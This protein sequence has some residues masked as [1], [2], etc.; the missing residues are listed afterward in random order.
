MDLFPLTVQQLHWLYYYFLLFHF[1]PYF[2]LLSLLFFISHFS[3]ILSPLFSLPVSL[4]QLT[5]MLVNSNYICLIFI[6]IYFSYN[7]QCSHSW[8]GVEA[9]T[10][11]STVQAY[12]AHA[13]SFHSKVLHLKSTHTNTTY[14]P[15]IH[16]NIHSHTYSFESTR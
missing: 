13:Y 15:Q 2:L 3:C 16:T 8:P 14:T 7:F 11:T 5:H 9:L 12:N 10:H 4:I 6:D 1:F